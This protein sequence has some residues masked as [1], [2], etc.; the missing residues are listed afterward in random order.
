MLL[1]E[2][3]VS[4]IF[5]FKNEETRKKINLILIP[6]NKNKKLTFFFLDNNLG[7]FYTGLPTYDEGEDMREFLHTIAQ[8]NGYA[9]SY[10]MDDGYA[11]LPN[12]V[13]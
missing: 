4:W 12:R 10:L 7:K 8:E 9:T 3:H 5:I 11:V 1:A 13:K 6:K 2:E